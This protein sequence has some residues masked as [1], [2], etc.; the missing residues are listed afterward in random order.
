MNYLSKFEDI[1]LSIQRLI[2]ELNEEDKLSYVVKFY[3]RE[4]SY[5]MTLAKNIFKDK[6]DESI[7]KD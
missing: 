7:K 6:Y 2:S 3:T 5:C 4:A 1:Q